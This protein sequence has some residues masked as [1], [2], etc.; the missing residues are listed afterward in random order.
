[1]IFRYWLIHTILFQ[2][3]KRAAS[4]E[5]SRRMKRRAAKLRRTKEETK[6]LPIPPL[7]PM[8]CHLV[9]TRIRHKTAFLHLWQSSALR[10]NQWPDQT[11][12]CERSQLQQL[13]GGLTKG[14][15]VSASKQVC[16]CACCLILGKLLNWKLVQ[17]WLHLS[18]QVLPREKLSDNF[19]AMHHPKMLPGVWFLANVYLAK[20]ES[21]Y[22]SFQRSKQLWNSL[23]HSDQYNG[24][25]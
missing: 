17:I 6:E 18:F 24:L 1:M 19:L 3:V 20:T 23:D 4:P 22:W 14:P 7:V 8:K 9:Q 21:R 12:E 15:A 11:G 10:K 25:D 16:H 5:G 13:R 2:M